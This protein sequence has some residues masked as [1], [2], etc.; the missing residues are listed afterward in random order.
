VNA[1]AVTSITNFVL[2][3][4]LFFLAGMLVKIPKARFSAVWFYSGMM[5]CLGVATLV[6]GIDHGFFQGPGLPRYFIQRLTWIVLGVMTFFLL[7]TIATQFFPRRVHRHF[8]IVGMIQFAVYAAAVL[9]INSFLIVILNYTPVMLLLLILSL[10]DLKNGSGLQGIIA[11]VLILFAASA[12][13]RV[14]MDIFS[15][16]DRNGLYHL[17]SMV[18]IVFM[19]LGGRHLRNAL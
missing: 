14:G 13:Q 11:G 8:L 6:G 19:Y 4:E 1:L 10:M 15:P 12:I 17:V 18:G 9:L 16:L 7:M 5:V 3:C 2:A